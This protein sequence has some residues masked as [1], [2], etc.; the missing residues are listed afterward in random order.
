MTPSRDQVLETLVRHRETIRAFG[1]KRLGLFG[2]CAR[3]D[4]AGAGDLDFLVDLQTK[5]FDAYMDLKAY[6]ESLFDCSVDLVMTGAVKPRL[7]ER[8]LRE[9]VHAPGL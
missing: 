2:S 4:S 7:R 6:L 5:T 8:I 9:V 1:V 3:G